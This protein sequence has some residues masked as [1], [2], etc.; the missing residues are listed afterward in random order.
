MHTALMPRWRLQG[1]SSPQSKLAVVQ[2]GCYTI[3]GARPSQPCAGP[4]ES[5][6]RSCRAIYALTRAYTD[7]TLWSVD[8]TG[9]SFRARQLSI[10]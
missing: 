10:A 3:A 2:G 7:R 8:A 5:D 1:P 4:P 6:A 9:A